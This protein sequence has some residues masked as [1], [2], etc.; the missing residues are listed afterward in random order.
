MELNDITERIIG[1]SYT[2]GRVLGYGFLEKVYE[3]SMVI[4]MQKTGLRVKQQHPISVYYDERVVGEY[5]ADLFVEEKVLVELK[6]IKELAK[7]HFAQCLNY[8]KATNLNVCLLINFG[9]T[10]V[11]IKRIVNNL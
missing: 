8:L 5:V 4:E 7:V 1:C 10:K 11:E 2:V 3:N 9:Q 6:S